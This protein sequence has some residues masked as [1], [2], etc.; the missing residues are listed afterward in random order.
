MSSTRRTTNIVGDKAAHQVC[1]CDLVRAVSDCHVSAADP[2]PRSQGSV[3]RR[4][5]VKR[6]LLPQQTEWNELVI[7][8]YISRQIR[9]HLST[10]SIIIGDNIYLWCRRETDSETLTQSSAL[11]IGTSIQL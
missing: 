7:Y 2:E 8:I 9:E 6:I 1:V 5:R 10:Y 3:L 4:R 11:I